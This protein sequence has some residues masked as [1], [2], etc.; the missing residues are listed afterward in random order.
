MQP[1]A[2]LFSRGRLS[3][4]TPRFTPMLVQILPSYVGTEYEFGAKAN[5][6]GMLL[7]AAWFNIDKANQ[8]AQPNPDRTFTYV[9]DGREVHQGLEL[10][11]TGNITTGLRILGG[12]TLMDAT[13]EKTANPRLTVNAR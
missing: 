2:N 10:T 8:Y 13:V 6:G 5:V 7:T 1:I 3:R 11:A 9:S 4:P 12:V